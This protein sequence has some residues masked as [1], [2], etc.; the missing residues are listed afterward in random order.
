VLSLGRLHP[1]KGLETL[2]RAWAKVE[3]AHPDWRLS[4]IGPGDERYVGELRAMS[5]A[6]GLGRVL[7]GGPIHGA[8]KW[9]SY[10][11]AD[12]F[13]LSSLNEN[14]GL[15]VAE[16]LAAGT[17]VIATTG[18]PWDR[19][20]TEGCGWYVEPAPEA[21]AAVLATAMAMPPPTLHG[22]GIKGRAWMARDFSWEQ[23]A[24]D[25]EDL[26]AWLVGRAGQPPSIR[27]K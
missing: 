12:L 21:L 25:M 9:E 2:L 4:L 16:A 11:A 26:Y 10:R 5:R 17:P 1:K 8:A 19:V 23:V 3:P 20:E 22:M 15:T 24:R 27:L 6:L 14:F 13:V 18:T 7:F